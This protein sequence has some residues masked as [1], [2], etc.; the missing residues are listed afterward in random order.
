M[1]RSQERGPQNA[2]AQLRP[3]R[4]RRVALAI[5]AVTSLT[6]GIGHRFYNEP[7]LTSGT[8]SPQ[9]W[10]APQGARILDS[11]ATQARREAARTESVK[12]L[13]V[14][15]TANR[16]I[17]TDL[18]Q[19]LL[20][21]NSLR[22]MLGAYPY[23]EPTLLSTSSQRYLRSAPEWEWLAVLELSRRLSQQQQLNTSIDA[24]LTNPLLRQLGQLNQQLSASSSVLQLHVAGEL[25]RLQ[26]RAVAG[27]GN[28]NLNQV[29]EQIQQA[30]S[31][32]QRALA[33]LDQLP[34]SAY[35]PVLFDLSD[36]QWQ[37]VQQGVW[38]ANRRLLAAG[39]PPGLP[40]PLQ[41]NAVLA[42]LDSLPPGPVQ[43]QA[44]SLVLSALQPTL[45][46]D[47]ERSQVQ[48][49][50]A[51]S[52]VEP[53]YVEV[54]KG[55]LIV[56]AAEPISDQD[57]LILDHFSLTQRQINWAGLAG[58][59]MLVGGAVA[60]FWTLQIRI[61]P[62]MRL[63]DNLLVLLL[64]LSVP[65]IAWS[66]GPAYTCLPAV[67]LLAASFYGSALGTTVVVL[68][69]SLLP[70][71]IEV[72]AVG[73]MPV[74]AGSLVAVLIAGRLRSR[75]E[76]ARLGIGIGLT[77]GST[78][79]IVSLLL[80]GSGF[81]W[82]TPAAHALSGLFWSVV[83]LGVSPYLEQAFDLVTPIRLAE[84]ANPNRSMLKRLATEA[85][86]TFQHT[87][88][89]ATLAE[90]A[91]Q[92]LSCNVELVRTGTLYHD[93]GKIHDPLGF[94]ENQMGGP[95]KHDEINDPYESA[96]IIKKHV[97]EGLVM[98]RRCSLP[99]AIR[100]FIPEH[101]GTML[102]AY[103]Y[104]QARERLAADPDL[105]QLGPVQESDFRYDGPIPQSRETG[106]V[107]LADSCEAALRS[108]KEASDEEALSMVNKI[109]KARWQDQQLVDSG[110]K[111]EEMPRI[112]DV[113][114]RVWKQHNH[115]RIRYPSAA[116]S[117]HKPHGTRS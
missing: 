65:T 31:R 23:L 40:E 117:V 107:M 78:Y 12:V 83:A 52:K 113:F 36:D 24:R 9:T 51:A 44:A 116:L 15:E 66:V 81:S 94:I 58:L 11:S 20:E 37:Q 74:L 104:H 80:Q 70:M 93:I 7:K 99:T 115:Q 109:L 34:G 5:L 60:L 41:R 35:T 32:Y 56:R 106:I 88:Y 29:I 30:R 79:L 43:N 26:L 112:A 4:S 1:A 6:G 73:L 49:E 3:C 17:T 13:R 90:A 61:R 2:L 42:Q 69:T 97:S 111:R 108:L 85:P 114:V 16:A 87:L 75:E 100:A 76:L 47:S 86:G 68:L 38:Q 89:V 71:G 92:E 57:F 25:S 64:S 82:L 101:Q 95:N 63:R 50:Q 102:I 105:A 72:S 28:P 21:G 91:A 18:G 33:A 53:I 46:V 54:S 48:A 45:V 27:N 59:S 98:A 96:R 39:I 22:E 55:E 67:G 14:D 10:Y 77:Q 110:L 19:R 8:P 84:L 103:F 62:A